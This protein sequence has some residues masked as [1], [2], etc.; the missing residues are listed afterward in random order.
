L[1]KSQLINDIQL[2]FKVKYLAATLTGDF[3]ASSVVKKAD[4]RLKFSVE[5]T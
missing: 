1:V 5:E 3:I 4:A 2:T